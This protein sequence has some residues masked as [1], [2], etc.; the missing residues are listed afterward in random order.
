MTTTSGI[1]GMI[2]TTKNVLL[3]FGSSFKGSG[4]LAGAHEGRLEPLERGIA[5]TGS[6]VYI[7]IGQDAAVNPGDV[8]IVFREVELDS[9]LYSLPSEAR[10]KLSSARQAVGELLV[11]K[12]GERAATALVT[13]STDG[14]VLGDQV[15][16]R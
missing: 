3:N 11:L 6:I 2:V 8:F 13:Y 9:N 16:R 12:V 5:S 14:L 7:D 10:K 15:E 4:T 1:H